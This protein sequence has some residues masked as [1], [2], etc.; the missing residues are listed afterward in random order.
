MTA[1]SGLSVSDQELLLL[2]AWERFSTE[3]L[4]ATLGVSRGGYQCLIR[5]VP[6]D[7]SKVVFVV[8]G[9]LGRLRPALRRILPPRLSPPLCTTTS[10]RPTSD[11]R[12]QPGNSKRSGMTPQAASSNDPSGPET[13]NRCP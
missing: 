1:L 11:A 4:A 5:V 7:V 3:Q 2:V 12:T 13:P 8:R 10:P 6:D 9:H